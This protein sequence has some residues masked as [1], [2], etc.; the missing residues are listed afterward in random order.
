MP[1]LE[2][3][4]RFQALQRTVLVASFSDKWLLKMSGGSYRAGLFKLWLAAIMVRHGPAP[5]NANR[6]ARDDQSRRQLAALEFI[7]GGL[8]AIQNVV[9]QFEVVTR[10][11]DRF[12]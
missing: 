9:N 1:A 12:R 11:D 5:A 3:L 2:L 8:D 10:G 4:P 7:R 6:V